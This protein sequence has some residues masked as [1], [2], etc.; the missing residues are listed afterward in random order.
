MGRREFKKWTRLKDGSWT[1]DAAVWNLAISRWAAAEIVGQDQA[2][3]AL[4]DLYQVFL[5]P[6]G[7]VRGNLAG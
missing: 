2:V 4:A 3:Q 1:P 5:S 7:L 6:S